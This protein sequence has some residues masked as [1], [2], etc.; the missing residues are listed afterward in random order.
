MRYPSGKQHTKRLCNPRGPPLSTSSAGRV[1]WCS[2]LSVLIPLRL[3]VP[4][5]CCSWCHCLG[6]PGHQDGRHVCC[7]WGHF[8]CR[9]HH[10]GRRGWDWGELGL[11]A[12]PLYSGLRSSWELLLQ[13]GWGRVGAGTGTGATRTSAA[14]GTKVTQAL[15]PRMLSSQWNQHRCGWEAR[16]LCAASTV[17]SGFSGSVISPMEVKRPDCKRLCYPLSSTTLVCSIPP[18]FKCSDVWILQHPSVLGGGTFDALWMF[19]L[20]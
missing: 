17:A 19:Y 12:I 3:L 1:T 16:F 6:H 8:V 18:T 20:L 15:L 11:Q 9:Y 5:C 4:C 10:H 2:P 14:G 13:E 7:M